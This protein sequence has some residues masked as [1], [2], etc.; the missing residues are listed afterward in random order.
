MFKAKRRTVVTMAAVVAVLLAGALAV[1]L[2]TQGNG[3]PAAQRDDNSQWCTRPDTGRS[4][5]TSPATSLT[6]TPI[7]L[8]SYRGKIVVLNFWGSWC[9]PCRAEGQRSRCSIEQYG[10]KGVAVP[11]RRRGGHPGERARLHP[12]RRH[13]LPERERRRTTRS[14][15]GLPSGGAGERHPDH[16]GDRQDRARRG[17]GDRRGQLRPDD[18]APA[19]TRR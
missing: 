8:S 5:P 12:R 15:S 10:S 14:S 13:H 11:R 7:K 9:A 17:H 16:R 18:H 2:L 3:Q 1:T 4:R 6:G 19:T